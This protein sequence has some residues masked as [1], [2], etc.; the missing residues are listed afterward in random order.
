MQAKVTTR[1]VEQAIAAIEALDLESIKR[2]MTDAELGEGWTPQ[3][4]DTIERAYRNYLTML[5]KYPEHT[6]E[7]LVSKDVDEFWHTHILHTMKYTE[8]CDRVF[9]AYLHHTPHIKDSAPAML[10]R[11][12]AS[13]EKT[14]RLYQREFGASQEKSATGAVDAAAYCGAAI[15]AEKAAYCGAALKTEKAAY[16]GAALKT[17]KAAYCGAA[18]RTDKAAY[19]GAAIDTDEA[20]YCGAAV[21]PDRLQGRASLF[22]RLASR[23]SWLQ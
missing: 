7:F 19:C 4:A 3:H 8:D 14:R 12:A 1:P 15:D 5:V 17:E 22:Q 9:G 10:E 23:C 21:S 13:A 2:R 16:C 18:L 11:R 20:A 6:E